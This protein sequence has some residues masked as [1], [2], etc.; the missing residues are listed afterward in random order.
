MK[1]YTA[2]RDTIIAKMRVRAAQR[3]ED[4]R[5]YLEENPTAVEEE[6]EKMREKY[7]NRQYSKNKKLIEEWLNNPIV[8]EPT[9]KFLNDIINTEKY[10]VLTPKLLKNLEELVKA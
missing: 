7:Y 9:K 8:N 1:Y 6:R 4:R 10:K 2:N 3:R 5:K